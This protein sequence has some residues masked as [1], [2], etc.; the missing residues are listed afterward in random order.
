MTR[1]DGWDKRLGALIEGA[2]HRHFVWGDHDCCTFALADFEAMTGKAAPNVVPWRSLIQAQRL[3]KQQ[4]VET[5]ARAWFGIPVP[6]WP[7]ARR[8]DIALIDSSRGRACGLES[9]QALAVVIGAFAACP[10]ERGLE[11]LPLRHVVKVWKV[12]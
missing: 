11:F 8:G 7:E 4:S 3:L 5:W 9:K 12:G 10:G 2:R 6:S 1:L